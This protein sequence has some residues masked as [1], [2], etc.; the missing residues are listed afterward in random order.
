MVMPH[1]MFYAPYLSDAD[2]RYKPGTDGLMLANP[3]NMILGDGKGPFGYVIIPCNEREKAIIVEDGKDLL[4][5]LLAYKAWFKI[6]PDSKHN[7]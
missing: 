7:H 3:D 5:R 4:N 1:Y 6:E 2:T